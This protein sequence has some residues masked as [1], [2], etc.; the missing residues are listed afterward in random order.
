MFSQLFKRSRPWI[1]PAIAD[2]VQ[3]AIRSAE[4]M[5][6]GEIR[7]FTERRCSYLDAVDRA[8]ELFANLSMHK[9]RQRNA[10]LVYWAVQDRQVAI[11]ADQG[12]HERL[13]QS[14]WEERVSL[15]M[16]HFRS[17]DPALALEGCVRTV[18]E[19]LQ[20]HFPYDPNSDQN[21]LSDAMIIGR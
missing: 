19:A 20:K 16:E 4:K 2:R 8:A 21:E 3:A 7:V 13:G 15:M 1:D 14:F 10:V 12:I 5:T 6:S 11:Y 18:A 17:N 9:T